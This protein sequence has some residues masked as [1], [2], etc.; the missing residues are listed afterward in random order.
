MTEVICLYRQQRK[1]SY[2]DWNKITMGALASVA[3]GSSTPVHVSFMH[4]SHAAA[5]IQHYQY[6]LALH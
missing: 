6:S 3:S 5:G 1:E 4:H 2:T